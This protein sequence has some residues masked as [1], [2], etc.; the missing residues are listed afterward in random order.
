MSFHDNEAYAS[1]Y[2]LFITKSNPNQWHDMNTF[3]DTFTAW[4][5]RKGA[6]LEY[7]GHYIVKDFDLI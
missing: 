6:A 1:N 3:L 2:G 4:E 7:T 5:V